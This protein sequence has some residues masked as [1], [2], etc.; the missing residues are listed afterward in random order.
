MLSKNMFRLTTKLPLFMKPK[1]E[2]NTFR[3][4]H[5]LFSTN[6]TNSTDKDNSRSFFNM[7]RKKKYLDITNTHLHSVV[8]QLENKDRATISR[9]V[10]LIESQNNDHRHKADKILEILFKRYKKKHGNKFLDQNL[11]A[12][13][14]GM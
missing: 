2:L 13:R 4:T 8:N 1:Y 5:R 11:P 3:T 14:I 9:V 7:I 6:K 10:T 12:F